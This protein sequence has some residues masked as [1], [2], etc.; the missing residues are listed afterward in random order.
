MAL[1]TSTIRITNHLREP[2]TYI[3]ATIVKGGWANAAQPQALIAANST[4]R[5]IIL[6]PV[7]GP[8]FSF[9]FL[10]VF[11]ADMDAQAGGGSSATITYRIG[12]GSQVTLTFTCSKYS[13]NDA[14]WLPSPAGEAYLVPPDFNLA[15]PLEGLL[16]RST[17]PD[18]MSLLTK[19]SAHFY[20]DPP[21]RT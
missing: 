12:S 5:P 4:T 10:R 14:A 17:P 2:L 16:M 9:F 3:N 7:V 13:D 21:T 1:L 15:G 11:G 19:Q 6:N 18:H 8:W 20:L